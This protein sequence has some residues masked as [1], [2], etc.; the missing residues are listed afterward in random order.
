MVL[1]N[2]IVWDSC[3]LK[4]WGMWIPDM[5]L[6]VY[7]WDAITCDVDDIEMRWLMVLMMVLKWDDCWCWWWRW[8]EMND[9][10][11]DDI[12]KIWCWCWWCHSDEMMLMLMMSSWWMYVVY[13]HGGTVTSW[14]SL[15]RE[16]EH[17][18]FLTIH[19]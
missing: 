15:E 6:Y 7:M 1:W 3:C 11:D 13:V 17:L 10:V 5:N 12:K 2:F 18:E 4:T 16:G 19:G 9:D 14:I 8:D